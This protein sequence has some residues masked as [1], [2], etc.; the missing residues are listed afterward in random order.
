MGVVQKVS[1]RALRTSFASQVQDVDSCI[2]A[3]V[4]ECDYL[5][6]NYI[7]PTRKAEPLDTKFI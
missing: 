3:V 1:P 5:P 7:I 2:H 4:S 6:M